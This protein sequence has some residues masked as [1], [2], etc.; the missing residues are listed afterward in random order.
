MEAARLFA[1]M[2][3]DLLAAAPAAPTTRHPTGTN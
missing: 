3:P 2:N 1:A